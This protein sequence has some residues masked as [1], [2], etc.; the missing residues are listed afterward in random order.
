M[1]VVGACPVG[2]VSVFLG[3]RH[4]CVQLIGHLLGV[5]IAEVGDERPCLLIDRRWGLALR[6]G[7][8]FRMATELSTAGQLPTSISFNPLTKL[9]PNREPFRQA[10]GTAPAEITARLEGRRKR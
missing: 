3:V 7:W 9:Q 6:C 8:S 5:E 1:P 4:R 10:G 2:A